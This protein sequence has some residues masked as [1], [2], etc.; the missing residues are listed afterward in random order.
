MKKPAIFIYPLTRR[1]E[2]KL[3]NPYIKDVCQAVKPYFDC[4]NYN[5]PS[6]IGF[7]NITK[8]FFKTKYIHLNWIEELPDKKGGFFQ[9][10]YFLIILAAAR[11]TGKKII[12]TIHNKSTHQ[13]KNLYIKNFL[14]YILSHYA[15][16]I[17]THSSE[18]VKYAFQLNPRIPKNRINFIHHPVK[19]RKIHQTN[20]YKYDVIIWGNISRYK[21]I[22]KFFEYLES[23]NILDR[24]KI[25]VAGKID[26]KAYEKVILSYSTENIT[27][28]NKFVEESE[29]HDLISNSR[30]ILFTYQR[31]YV[32]SSGALADSLNFGKPVI[33][34]DIGAF[35]D[36]AKKDLIYTYSDMKEIPALIN[37]LTHGMFWQKIQ[38]IQ[39]FI[40]ENSWEN[41]GRKLYQW[42][43]QNSENN[44]QYK[45]QEK[46]DDEVCSYHSG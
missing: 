8:Y 43:N 37:K 31:E 33:G 21:G 30:I 16:Y 25:L 27:I 42:L 46:Q 23:K 19:P 24:F 1:F 38:A 2:Q 9:T 15:N 4:V 32:L 40:R 13:Q 12:W 22:H 34:P 20:K 44:E 6:G 35:A 29:L 18:G 7:L 36:L 26:D 17:I 5:K 45:I 11:L 39:D 10:S 14:L 41:Y 3:A 28:I